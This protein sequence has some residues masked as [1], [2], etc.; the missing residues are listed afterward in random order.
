MAKKKTPGQGP[1]DIKTKWFMTQ[2]TDSLRRRLKEYPELGDEWVKAQLG[3]I[4]KGDL[5]F[6]GVSD[7]I[8]NRAVGMEASYREHP[9]YLKYINLPENK[10]IAQREAKRS[11]QQYIQQAPTGYPWQEEFQKGLYEAGAKPIAQQFAQIGQ[12]LPLEGTVNDILQ[13]LAS[14]YKQEFGGSTGPQYFSGPG[15]DMYR[16]LPSVSD[17]LNFLGQQGNQAYQ[18]VN[19]YIQQ[20]IA[21]AT[22]YAQAAYNKGG[23]L[24]QGGLNQAKSYLAAAQPYAKRAMGMG[25]DIYNQI[26]GPAMNAGKNTIQSLGNLLSMLRGGV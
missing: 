4:G 24:A 5:Y 10:E 2:S 7:A 23:E 18:T 9:E 1:T 3:R 19:P 26:Q 17:S 11:G 12:P 22:P 6:P 8:R 16:N 14:Q 25:A 13:G 21:A 20:G 15:V